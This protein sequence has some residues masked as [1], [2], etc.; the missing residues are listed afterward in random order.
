M[1]EQHVEN[2]QLAETLIAM[3]KVL[4]EVA[5]ERYHQLVKHGDQTH[6]LNGT[7][8]YALGSLIADGRHRYAGG[9][10]RWAKARTDA[11]SQ[12]AGDG[13]VTFEHILTEE[14]AEAMTESDPA[15]LRAEL[16]QVA[17]VAVQWI[18]AIDARSAIRPGSP[19]EEGSNG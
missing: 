2:A 3:T 8:P 10:A 18:E 1:A 17:A 11:A 19:T 14:W 4:G 15:R 13:A 16:M 6:L 12:G 7:G 5:E 9:L